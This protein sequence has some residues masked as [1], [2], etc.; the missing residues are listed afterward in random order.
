M[1][2]VYGTTWQASWTRLDPLQSGCS[3]TV[4]LQYNKLKWIGLLADNCLALSKSNHHLLSCNQEQE[5]S[6]SCIFIRW[7]MENLLSGA[8]ELRCI[9]NRFGIAG[10]AG[11]DSNISTENNVTI[12]S[13][14]LMIIDTTDSAPTI[15]TNFNTIHNLFKFL[16]CSKN[17]C[18]NSSNQ[19]NSENTS[20]WYIS[21]LLSSGKRNLYNSKS[22]HDVTQKYTQHYFIFKK[23]RT[24]KKGFSGY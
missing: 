19:R 18:H 22:S 15:P 6:E 16:C 1:F 12:A 7:L 13:F 4:S 11:I 17:A 3:Y 21:D 23:D 24:L 8:L 10:N 5:L 9:Y 2:L 14:E 20:H